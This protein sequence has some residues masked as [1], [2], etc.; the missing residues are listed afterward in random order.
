MTKFSRI[1]YHAVFE[2][3]FDLQMNSWYIHVD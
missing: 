3:I 2:C 1:L